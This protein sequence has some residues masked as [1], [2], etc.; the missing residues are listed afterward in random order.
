[1]ASFNSAFRVYIKKKTGV[2][3]DATFMDTFMQAIKDHFYP[4]EIFHVEGTITMNRLPH[5][6]KHSFMMR[7]DCFVCDVYVVEDKTKFDAT[8][9]LHTF[10]TRTNRMYITHKYRG[11]YL[12]LVVVYLLLKQGF[13][14]EE[15]ILEFE[16]VSE[17]NY[18]SFP[19][20]EDALSII[21]NLKKNIWKEDIMFFLSNPLRDI[22]NS[23]K[24]PS[25]WKYPFLTEFDD[26]I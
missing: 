8:I 12:T 7:Y 2:T 6:Q 11:F 17:E 18:I 9:Y 5:Q 24:F 23:E 22:L 21:Y 14:Q 13:E 3:R 1:M 26:E 15:G 20:M 25:F 16:D 19:T 10:G 4:W